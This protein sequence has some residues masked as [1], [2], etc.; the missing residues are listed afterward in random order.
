MQ[1][2]TI[3]RYSQEL[4]KLEEYVNNTYDLVAKARGAGKGLIKDKFP[5]EPSG[6]KGSDISDSLEEIDSTISLLLDSIN[7]ANE[8]LDELISEPCDN[9]GN[10]PTWSNSSGELQCDNCGHSETE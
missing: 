9:C 1:E 5:Y 4:Y 2:N 8:A 3:D 10:G 7:Q 6:F